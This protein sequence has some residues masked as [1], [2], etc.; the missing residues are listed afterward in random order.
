MDWYWNECELMMCFLLDFIFDVNIFFVLDFIFDIFGYYL[1]E[2]KGKLCFEYF[3]LDEVLFV[4]LIYSWGVFMDKVVVL[5][6][7][8]ILF[9]KGEYV[10][11][12]CC[13]IVVYI[14][15]VVF[16]SIYFRGDKSESMFC[17]FVY[18]NIC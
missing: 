10:N 8:W 13:F 15:L 2:V 18:Y 4:C 5:Y 7:V 11:C 9:S 16:I 12:E 14:V 3:Y 17:V 1:D 6:Y